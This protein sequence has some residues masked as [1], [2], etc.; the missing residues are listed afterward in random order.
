MIVKHVKLYRGYN[1]CTRKPVWHLSYLFLPSGITVKLWF[2]SF[3]GA[4]A[5]LTL[6][7]LGGCI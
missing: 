7:E 6:L 5:H 4:I 2:S 3:D 1:K